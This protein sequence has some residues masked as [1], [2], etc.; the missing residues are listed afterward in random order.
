MPERCIQP[1]V[2]AFLQKIKSSIVEEKVPKSLRNDFWFGITKRSR[3]LFF[4]PNI[5]RK[6]IKT[7]LYMKIYQMKNG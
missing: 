5:S 2:K 3:I 6:E 7:N 1:K 4:N